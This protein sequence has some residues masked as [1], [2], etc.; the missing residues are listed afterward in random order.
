MLTW[1]FGGASH[2]RTTLPASACCSPYLGRK[3]AEGLDQQR[4]D[5]VRAFIHALGLQGS[6]LPPY[7][8][9]VH[10]RQT[11]VRKKKSNKTQVKGATPGR[12]QPR[13]PG[14]S[15]HMPSMQHAHRGCSGLFSQVTGPDSTWA[16]GGRAYTHIRTHA[17]ACTL[18]HTRTHTCMHAYKCVHATL[19]QWVSEPHPHP[20]LPTCHCFDEPYF[21]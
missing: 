18:M 9:N 4:L 15:T 10:Y 17:R 13:G 1:C 11:V 5:S 19:Q 3:L 12:Q 8:A 20:C 7:W 21:V 6:T 2:S 16:P 14:L